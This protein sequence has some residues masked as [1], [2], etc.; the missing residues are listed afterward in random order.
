[1]ARTNRG[2]VDVRRCGEYEGCVALVKPRGWLQT[3]ANR[4]TAVFETLPPFF[5]QKLQTI[6]YLTSKFSDGAMLT[7]KLLDQALASNLSV[8]TLF[9]MLLVIDPQQCSHPLS[10]SLSAYFFTPF[11][12]PKVLRNFANA[13]RFSGHFFSLLRLSFVVQDLVLNI[14]QCEVCVGE[15]SPE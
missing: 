5:S 2:P 1:M 6:I 4:L 14:E 13:G 3:G 10:L 9:G 8:L 7:Q 12:S 11:L 15:V